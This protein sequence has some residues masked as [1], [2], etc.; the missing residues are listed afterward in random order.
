MGARAIVTGEKL[1]ATTGEFADAT[2]G[3][4]LPD[5]ARARILPPRATDA[6]SHEASEQPDRRTSGRGSGDD[7]YFPR[8]SNLASF[9]ISSTSRFRSARPIRP[10]AF[11]SS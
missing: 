11:C 3:P 9:K 10:R 5:H 2:S 6:E 8:R 4:L 7:S 1:P